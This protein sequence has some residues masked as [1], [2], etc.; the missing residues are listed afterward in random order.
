MRIIVDTDMNFISFENH[1]N[2]SAE[3]STADFTI[4]LLTNSS[5]IHVLKFNYHCKLLEYKLDGDIFKFDGTQH[6]VNELIKKAKAIH[7]AIV[8][9]SY[10]K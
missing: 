4:K 6:E 1:L 3:V 7:K 10:Y 2:E 9:Y 5:L 8:G